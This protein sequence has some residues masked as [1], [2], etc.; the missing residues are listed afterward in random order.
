MPVNWQE[1]IEVVQAHDH[2]MLTSHIRPDCDA[3]GSVLGMM[4][5]LEQLGKD[6]IIVNGQPT[7]P[8][9]AFIDPENRIKAIGVDI[10][11]EDL[12]DRDIHMVLDTSAWAQLGPMGE[13]IK[14]MDIPLI[15]LDHHQ[16]EDD[17]GAKFFKDTTAEAAGK[18]VADAA[19]ALGVEWNSRMARPLFAAVATDTGWYRF[20]SAGAGTYQLASRL[21]EAGAV[22]AEIYGQLYEQET[23]GRLRLR[24]TVLERVRVELEGRLAH[25]FIRLADFENTGAVPT[26]TEDLVN[27]CLTIK[28][29]D[30]AFIL[31]EQTPDVYKVSFRSRC[32]LDC[33]ELAREFGGGGH[34]AAAG[35]GIDG[36]FEEC[37]SR[38]LDAMIAKLQ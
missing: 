10:Q 24:G 16:G 7:P 13:V 17:L 22:P 15:V 23:I 29:T 3:L 35:A 8:N 1:F 27:L 28:G 34:K 14:A 33:S 37:Q 4:D 11:L 6:V 12:Q 9:L 18:L 38:L 25:T 26:D 21:V 5:V 31:V 30:A 19:D 20:G 36:P 32:T 2:F